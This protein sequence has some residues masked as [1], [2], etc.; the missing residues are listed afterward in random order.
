MSNIKRFF[1]TEKLISYFD[2]QDKLYRMKFKLT[3]PKHE[4]I[5]HVS[6]KDYY[7]GYPVGTELKWHIYNN[8]I[9]EKIHMPYKKYLV[10]EIM[11]NVMLTMFDLHE[12]RITGG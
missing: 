2:K 5:I 10:Q 4:Y 12:T 7:N 11:D 1:K 6:V 3:I 9:E 8:G